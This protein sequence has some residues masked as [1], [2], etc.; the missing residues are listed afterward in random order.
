MNI[1]KKFNSFVRNKK[2]PIIIKAPIVFTT[3]WIFQ[4]I[5]YMDLTEKIFKISFDVILTVITYSITSLIVRNSFYVL[6]LVSLFIAHT[7]NL[8]FNGQIPVTMKN[9]GLLNTDYEKFQEYLEYLRSCGPRNTSIK[10]IFA[11]G[12]FS[13]NS[14]SV[15]SDLDIRIIRTP[16]IKNKMLSC[17]FIVK[18]RSK[19]TFS[20]FPLDIYAFNKVEDIVMV[21]K[22]VKLYDPYNLF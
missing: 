12:S 15:Q 3:S 7:L 20:M 10:A 8:I 6:I 11:Y 19:A 13:R 2:I 1:N 17:F 4:G 21:E 9:L 18:E 16:S 14:I 22:P 5:L